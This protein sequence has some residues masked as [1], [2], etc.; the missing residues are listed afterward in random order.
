MI[1]WE[2]IRE[3]HRLSHELKL[4]GNLAA[5]LPL[6]QEVTQLLEKH[7][8]DAKKIASS[9]NYLAYVNLQIGDFGA[10]EQAA[11]RSLS[12]YLEHSTE[13]DEL[14]ATYFWML[15]MVLEKQCRFTEALPHAEEA[16]D[17]FARLHGED[18]FVLAR[19]ADLE[20]IRDQSWRG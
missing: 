10:A 2:R 11:R 20:K 17:L 5:M 4:K 16:L 13:R 8:A 7:G 12:Y 3:L 6:C 9:W 19:R 14:L 1:P 18:D 15:S